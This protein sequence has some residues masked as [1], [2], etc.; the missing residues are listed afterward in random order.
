[1]HPQKVF[2]GNV[3]SL[4]CLSCRAIEQTADRVFLA[5]QV[6]VRLFNQ[7]GASLQQ[8]ILELLALADEADHFHKRALQASMGGRVASV[9]GSVTTITGLILAPFT[10]GSSIIVTAVGIGVATAGTITSASAH[11]TDS[12]HFTLDRKKVEKMIEGYEDIIKEIRECME[13]VQVGP[14]SPSQFKIDRI[15]EQT[16][17]VTSNVS[18]IKTKYKPLLFP[19]NLI[20]CKCSVVQ[21]IL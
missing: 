13:F 3:Y 5:A 10:F 1:M 17:L 12:V 11:I 6:F 8:R 15:T 19:Q 9:V 2:F 14:I 20:L 4:P 7:R 18:S 16:R 21:Y